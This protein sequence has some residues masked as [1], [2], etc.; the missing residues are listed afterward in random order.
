[1]KINKMI[2]AY[3]L[4]LGVLAIGLYAGCK[5]DTF[6]E[7]NGLTPK[8]LNAA[9]TVTPVT[10]KAN[11]YVITANT[12]S[13]L[14]VKWDR[15]DG[16]GPYLGKTLDTLF[17]PD[18]GTYNLTL[19]AIGAGGISKTAT[20]VITVPV[21][22]PL[23]GNLVKGGKFGA[24]DDAFWTHFKVGGGNN[25]VINTTNGVMTSSQTNYNA[26][27]IAQ[28]ITL[29][30]GQ[31]YSVDLKVSSATGMNGS[32]FEVWIDTKQP[33]NGQDYN[34]GI[35]PISLNTFAGCGSSAF[36]GNLSTLSCATSTNGKNNLN[37]FTVAATGTYYLVVKNGGSNT[38]PVTFTNVTLRGVH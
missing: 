5:P 13:V 4:A 29:T 12:N 20:Q 8:N 7:G 25:M 3:T 37:P 6:G 14:A 18:A 2:K 17:Y 30:A 23:S 1:M 33:V 10:G 16:T 32:W 21:S 19:T 35:K 27:A 36:S 11:Y 28:A 22:D 26:G 24:G 34:T 38:G 31:K 9:F 15:G